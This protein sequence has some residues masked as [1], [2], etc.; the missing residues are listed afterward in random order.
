MSHDPVKQ[1]RILIGFSRILS[2]SDLKKAACYFSLFQKKPRS[3]Q[4][5]ASRLSGY[6]VPKTCTP[7]TTDLSKDSNNQSE[8][9]TSDHAQAE[10]AS[11]PDK[12][13]V[14][15]PAVSAGS[16]TL[17]SDP[18]TS[19]RFVVLILEPL[20]LESPSESQ[21]GISEFQNVVDTSQ[22]E[23]SKSHSIAETS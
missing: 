22:S 16:E 19:E 6:K 1:Y 11:G 20:V 9:P 7:G 2:S 12:D 5:L 17:R 23:T 21:S 10:M 15:S 4:S 8:P 18:M 14:T 13:D 3:A